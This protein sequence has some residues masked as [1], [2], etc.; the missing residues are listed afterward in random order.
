[1]KILLDTANLEKIREYV[2]S[3]PIVGVTTN[4]T[5]LTREGGS[6]PVD[7]L[8]RIRQVLGKDRELHVQLTETT[9]KK[10][11]EEAYIITR[12]LG[13]NTYIKVPVSDVGLKVTKKLTEDGINVTQTAILTATQAM[14]A[15]EAGAK[16]VAPYVSRLDNIMGDGISTIAD[17]S[18]IFVNG[19][20][21]TKILAASF[22]TAKQ[23]LDTALAGAE[24]ATVSVDIFKKLYEHPI[25][26][27]S[28]D[29]FTN[30]WTNTYGD[31][32]LELFKK[33]NP[34]SHF[35]Y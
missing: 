16:Y 25:T 27:S 15:A 12:I 33:V 2:D 34:N 30:D 24:T 26:S 19:G 1:M 35:G 9:Y 5:I 28:I 11:I 3:F 17:I 20:Y 29:G 31:T 23:V 10:M 21:E 22:K 4:P 7:T 32:L 18:E 14:L 8:I 13:D 6:D